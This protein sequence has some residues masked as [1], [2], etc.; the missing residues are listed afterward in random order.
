MIICKKMFDITKHKWFW[1][2]E[3]R[4]E[5]HDADEEV[6]TFNHYAMDQKRHPI[7]Y[8]SSFNIDDAIAIAKHFYEQASVVDRLKFITSITGVLNVSSLG[9]IPQS[10][11]TITHN[12]GKI[13]EMQRYD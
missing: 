13:G 8:S 5:V 2:N 4:L 10:E 12:V 7:I 1:P 6:I 9:A 3:N 11:T